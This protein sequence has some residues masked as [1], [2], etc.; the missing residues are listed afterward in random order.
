MAGDDDGIDVATYS[1]DVMQ[2]EVR[3]RI[4]TGIN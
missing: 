4:V 1:T 3:G 2:R